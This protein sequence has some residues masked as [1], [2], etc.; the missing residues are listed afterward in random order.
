MD[1]ELMGPCTPWLGIQQDRQ[2]RRLRTLKPMDSPISFSKA[3]LHSQ[4]HKQGV[5]L[6]GHSLAASFS[7]RLVA[8]TAKSPPPPPPPTPSFSGTMEDEKPYARGFGACFVFAN[9]HLDKR[10]IARVWLFP[11]CIGRASARNC[12]H[13]ASTSAVFLQP[14]P[15]EGAASDA[16]SPQR[17]GP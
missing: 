14:G 3:G 12:L 11:C 8:E 17:S 13:T 15:P 4:Q 7:L 6:L 2:H 1:G 5:W 9:I 16:Q 10:S